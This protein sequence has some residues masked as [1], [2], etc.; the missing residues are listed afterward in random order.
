MET[1]LS[2]VESLPGLLECIGE[3]LPGERRC[4]LAVRALVRAHQIERVVALMGAEADVAEGLSV[5]RVGELLE[6]NPP[7]N[8]AP[9]HELRVALGNVLVDE[10]AGLF[11]HPPFFGR[12]RG[13]VGGHGGWASG[14]RLRARFAGW[15]WYAPGAWAL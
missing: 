4:V 11:D 15:H 14:L 5:V 3:K 8:H 1:A 6:R 12:E 13:Q 10:G 7:V 9:V 2:H